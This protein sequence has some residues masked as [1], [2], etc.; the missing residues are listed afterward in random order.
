MGNLYQQC[1]A[2]SNINL[3]FFL[4]T[5]ALLLAFVIQLFKGYNQR[6]L[7]GQVGLSTQSNYYSGSSGGNRDEDGSFKANDNSI[8][9]LPKRVQYLSD[10]CLEIAFAVY[11]LTAV[12]YL[13]TAVNQD[14][15]AKAGSV[16]V[17]AVVGLGFVGIWVGWF[18]LY[19]IRGLS[20]IKVAP[21]TF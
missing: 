1:N 6:I 15:V 11:F 21:T 3:T 13:L 16:V 20:F 9:E 5:S 12:E 2:I 10:I 17:L 19:P 14:Q 4:A 18:W 8:Y 7:N